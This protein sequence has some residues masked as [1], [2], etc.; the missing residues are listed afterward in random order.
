MNA[1][2]PALRTILVATDGS[3]DAARAARIAADIAG[4]SGAALHL[5][6]AW[7]PMP[8]GSYP[9]P[10]RPTASTYQHYQADAQG[11][12]TRT[13]GELTGSAQIAATHLHCGPAVGS[14]TSLGE[15]I[16]ADLI[17]LGS[18]GMG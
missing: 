11:V 2:P 4:R 17:V 5:I 7:R 1:N 12:L 9:Y 16:R 10:S 14:I 8:P 13:V 6:H 15:E 18:R 3:P